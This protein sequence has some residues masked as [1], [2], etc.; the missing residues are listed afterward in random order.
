MLHEP[1]TKRNVFPYLGKH[2][3]EA[4]NLICT[5]SNH[6]THFKTILKLLTL[7]IF[8]PFLGFSLLRY[9]LLVISLLC[10]VTPRKELF[11]TRMIKF[12]VFFV[13][14]WMYN[15]IKSALKWNSSLNK[16]ERTGIK[17]TEESW[18]NSFLKACIVLNGLNKCILHR[19]SI[20]LQTNW[21]IINCRNFVNRSIID[22][23]PHKQI[24]P[25]LVN[26]PTYTV[27]ETDDQSRRIIRGEG[28]SV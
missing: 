24:S 6:F 15:L 17:T 12:T 27:L 14:S 10:L 7:S 4:F 9:S 16:H 3:S 1:K 26:G 25:A 20:E 22:R 18:S 11:C 2:A 13:Q 5:L 21:A 8:F 19:E 28:S 23:K